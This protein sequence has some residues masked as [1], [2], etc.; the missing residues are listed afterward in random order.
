[1]ITWPRL[2]LLRDSYYY[3]LL[4]HYCAE[5]FTP[6]VSVLVRCY[7]TAP[8]HRYYAVVSDDCRRVLQRV[9]LALFAD[10][11]F[12]RATYVCHY[13]R[14]FTR[15]YVVNACYYRR[16]RVCCRLLLPCRR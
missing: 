2:I 4:L 8:R 3:A 16:C 15:A 5:F 12:M 6:C 13:F 11:Q 14:F 10:F 1:M 7:F 9:P